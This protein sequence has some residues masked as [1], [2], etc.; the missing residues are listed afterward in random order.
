MIPTNI[1]FANT[2]LSKE[3]WGKTCNEWGDPRAE[4]THVKQIMYTSATGD[5]SYRFALFVISS[6]L[7]NEVLKLNGFKPLS[8]EGWISDFHLTGVKGNYNFNTNPGKT[9]LHRERFFRTLDEAGDDVFSQMA[10]VDSL[11]L[12][13]L[14]GFCK[15][16][17]RGYAVPLNGIRFK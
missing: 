12:G 3:P 16:R 17:P 1:W 4:L 2:R 7:Y 15:N 8:P 5:F 10:F 13:E 9:L 14:E 6:R 11:R